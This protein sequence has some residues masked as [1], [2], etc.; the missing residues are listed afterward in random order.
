MIYSDIG[1]EG[2]KKKTRDAGLMN[3]KKKERGNDANQKWNDLSQQQKKKRSRWNGNERGEN[4]N[5]R[6][7][8]KTW[9]IRFVF[10][11]LINRALEEEQKKKPTDVCVRVRV[12]MYTCVCVYIK[13]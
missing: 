13:A 1:H 5:K 2:Q 12:R 6:H 11:C 8:N 9:D 7:V 10:M 3:M 4:N